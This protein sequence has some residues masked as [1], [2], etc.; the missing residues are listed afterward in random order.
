MLKELKTHKYIIG[1]VIAATILRTWMLQTK[2]IFFGDA[3]R[4]LLVARTSLLTRT[5][6][7]LGIP[8]SVPRFHQGP[9]T[10]WIEMITLF[11]SRNN[12]LAVSC[13]FAF[14]SIAA[15]I[16]VYELLALSMKPRVGIFAA[17]FLAFSPLAIAHARVPYH[18]TPIP[19]V[20]TL[21]FISLFFLWKKKTNDLFFAVFAFCFMFQFELAL[22][23]LILLLPYVLWRT[24]ELKKSHIR[25]IARQSIPAFLIGLLPEL[26]FDVTHHFAQLGGFAVW[27]VYRIVAF[28]GYKHDHTFSF[29]QLFETLSQLKIFFERIVSVDTLWLA[30]LCLG[31]TLFGFRIFF[32]QRKK[33]ALP[34]ILELT[35]LATGLLLIG[36]I[37]HS[38]PSEA[39]FPPFF[40]LFAI[41]FGFSC[42]Q[43]WMHS[44]IGKKLLPFF[45]LLYALINSVNI[46]QSNFFASTASAFSYGPSIGEQREV[47]QKIAQLSHKRFQFATLNES[48]KFPT[49][50]DNLRW[51]AL[52]KD[53]SEDPTHGTAFYIEN[54]NSPLQTNPSI[55]RYSFPTLDVYT[56]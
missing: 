54:K 46:A 21:Y 51:L 29:H 4:D 19:F 10:I 11:I 44:G 42:E 17:F 30:T 1:I 34:H 38:S 50:F 43:I 23:P 32:I 26:I 41:L 18:I 16:G 14:I 33:I 36:D 45:F 39:Y 37:I 27:L 25:W 5:L 53:L 55:I 47:V 7:L 6:P 48:G 35:L 56:K 8:S 31:I 3:A 9:V 22:A 2:A 49:Y 28:F 20:L 40:I 52:E 13:V 15:V 24:K 12:T